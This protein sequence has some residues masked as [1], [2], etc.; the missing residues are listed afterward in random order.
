MLKFFAQN[1]EDY[2][3]FYVDKCSDSDA[4]YIIQS[5]KFSAVFTVHLDFV[6]CLAP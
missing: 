5:L 1:V 6:C 2:T 3:S 4:G